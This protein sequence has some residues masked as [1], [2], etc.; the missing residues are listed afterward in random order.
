MTNHHDGHEMP[1]E[2]QVMDMDMPMM[3]MYFYFGIPTVD[4][5]FQGWLPINTWRELKNRI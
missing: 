2:E 4:I 1:H 5:L 3:P